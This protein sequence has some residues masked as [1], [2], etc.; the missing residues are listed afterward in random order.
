MATTQPE[1]AH[2]D[3]ELGAGVKHDTPAPYSSG[4]MDD[5]EKG[6]DSIDEKAGLDHHAQVVD[7]DG[8]AIA[9]ENLLANGKGEFEFLSEVEKLFL[10]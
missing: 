10:S 7:E 5:D 1:F 4:L 6:V 8:D 3:S 9:P 2:H